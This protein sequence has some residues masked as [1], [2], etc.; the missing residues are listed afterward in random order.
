MITKLVQD[1]AIQ[2]DIHSYIHCWPIHYPTAGIIPQ[3]AYCQDNVHHD[4]RHIDC[5]LY[6]ALVTTMVL[7][8]QP[9][10]ALLPDSDR[11]GA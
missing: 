10:S 9:L 5:G 7:S 3:L 4:S 2:R 1:E 6:A 11:A 8:H